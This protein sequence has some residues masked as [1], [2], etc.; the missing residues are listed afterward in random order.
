ML[1]FI[2]TDSKP[3]KHFLK[4]TKTFFFNC[5]LNALGEYNRYI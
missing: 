1:Y 3:M 5:F 4:Y 2:T